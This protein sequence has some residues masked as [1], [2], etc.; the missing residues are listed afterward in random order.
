MLPYQTLPLSAT[1]NLNPHHPQHPANRGDRRSLG[2]FYVGTGSAGNAG[3]GFSPLGLPKHRLVP[4]KP[5]IKSSN[6][7]A[8]CTEWRSNINPEEPRLTGYNQ[9][10]EVRSDSHPN[11]GQKRRTY[12]ASAA[13][14]P[15]ETPP[16]AARVNPRV[17]IAT[18]AGSN[19]A[20]P[21]G[22]NSPYNITQ[23]YACTVHPFPNVV[24]VA[25]QPPSIGLSVIS[26]PAPVVQRPDGSGATGDTGTRPRRPSNP[27]TNPTR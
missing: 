5:M 19:T 9:M 21:A 2:S 27:L 17:A 22:I 11:S 8:D 6:S 13:K 10:Y 12:S 15:N 7:V 16:N 1:V 24:K 18:S 14:H 4:R 25:H 3:S 26:G 20:S 23:Q